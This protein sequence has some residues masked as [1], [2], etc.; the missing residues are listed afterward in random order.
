MM[1][2]IR[3]IFNRKPGPVPI[4]LTPHDGDV[5]HTMVVGTTQSGKSGYLQA[6]ADRLGISYDE[7]LKS[8]DPTEEQKAAAMAL[9][10]QRRKRAETRINAVR[11]AYWAG[12]DTDGD[13]S[14]F[15]NLYDALTISNIVE[16]PSLEQIKTLFMMLPAEIIGQGIA[17]GFTDTEVRESIYN[18]V[19]DNREAVITSV[20][21]VQPDQL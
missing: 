13:F 15:D 11:E 19:A 4:F 21:A 10:E 3:Y 2:K 18:F 17:W 9:Q 12:S 1:D 6:Y 14:D 7:L 16:M 20:T 8:M 5:L